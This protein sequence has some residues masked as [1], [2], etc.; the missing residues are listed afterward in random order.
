MRPCFSYKKH[1]SCKLSLVKPAG[2]ETLLNLVLTS[3]D[4]LIKEIKIGGSLG[5]SSHTLVE[6]MISRNTGLAK[7]RVRNLKFR[8]ANLQLFVEL[9]EEISW[10]AVL[11]DRGRE[12]S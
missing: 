9:V 5:C 3:A 7:S 1:C 12:Q 8:G 10:E 2:G 6:F 11:R 4:E